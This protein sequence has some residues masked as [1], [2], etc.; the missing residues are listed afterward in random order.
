MYVGIDLGTSGIKAV[1]TAEDGRLLGQATAPLQVSTPRP[2]WGEQDPAAWWTATVAAMASL[3]GGH[4]LYGVRAV[5][6]PGQMHG[7][8]LLDGFCQP[9]RLSTRV[10]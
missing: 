7:A 8:V 1:L 2:L 6:L 5:G 4:D 3:R 9:S 10:G